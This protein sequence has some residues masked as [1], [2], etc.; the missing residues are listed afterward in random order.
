MVRRIAT[1]EEGEA[2]EDSKRHAPDI[3]RL[4]RRS[5]HVSRRGSAVGGTSGVGAGGLST[6]VH[7]TDRTAVR[8]ALEGRGEVVVA[9]ANVNSVAKTTVSAKTK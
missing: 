1:R 6:V 9:A 5:C 7:G 2:T 3:V 4:F 8:G